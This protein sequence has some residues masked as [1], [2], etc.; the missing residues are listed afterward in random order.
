MGLSRQEYWSGVPL[1]LILKQHIN[2]VLEKLR[3]LK[4][5]W[6]RFGVVTML[7]HMGAGKGAVF[8]EINHFR[9]E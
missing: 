1:Q 9:R 6:F 4:S 7:E 2:T 8:I 3:M 5:F